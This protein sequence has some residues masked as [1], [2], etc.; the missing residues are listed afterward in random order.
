MKKVELN[1]LLNKY[2]SGESSEEEERLLKE[3]F[4]G[5]DVPEEY[6]AEK[7]IF[8]QYSLSG[9][10]PDPSDNFEERIIAGIDEFEKERKSLKLRRIILYSLSTAAGLI[11][12]AGSYFFLNS[13]REPADTF[14]DPKIAYAETMKILLK[15]STQL[16]EGNK[17][18]EPLGR[19]NK[20]KDISFESINK[21]TRIIEKGLKSIKNLDKAAGLANESG[22]TNKNK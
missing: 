11:I 2:Y 21:S 20:M 12:V 5:N 14:S 13:N 17:A 6:R 1:I 4:Q 7:E 10:V 18:L 3:F 8:R 19:I 15:V 16:N 22:N 9:S